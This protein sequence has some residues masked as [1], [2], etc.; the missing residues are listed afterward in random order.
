M[1]KFLFF[2]VALVLVSCTDQLLVDEV[3]SRPVEQ[4]AA[5]EVSVLMEKARW[6]DGE[7]YVKLADCYRDGKGVKQDF[8]SMLGMASFADE[9]G[10]IKRME[11][12]ISSLPTESEYKMV[13]D[14]M[15][16]FSRGHHDEALTMA[17]KL[18]AQDCP[19]GYTVKGIILTEQGNVE[20]GKILLEL[21]AEEGSGFAGLYLC[22]P[23]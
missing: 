11:D 21:A 15:E 7:A 6:G 20:E 12:Y 2:V 22:V 23:D 1:K 9:Y 19:E 8:I 13:F 10:G 3:A 5:S 4:D 18:I 17:E 16:E 14:A